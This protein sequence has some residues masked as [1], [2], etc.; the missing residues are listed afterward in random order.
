MRPMMTT[1]R[2]VLVALVALFVSLRVM[3]RPI[4]DVT[5]RWQ[6]SAETAVGRAESEWLISRY[7]PRTLPTPFTQGEPQCH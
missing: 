1:T 5:A 7:G 3:H 4:H 2:T 6:R